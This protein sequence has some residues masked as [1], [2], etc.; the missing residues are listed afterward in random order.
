MLLE[1]DEK[2]IKKMEEN[3]KKI[4]GSILFFS[5]LAAILYYTWYGVVDKIK[6]VLAAQNS[7]QEFADKISGMSYIIPP[8]F[9]VLGLI[10]GL[11]IASFFISKKYQEII[12]KLLKK[13]DT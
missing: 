5:S 4:I 1:S 12:N 3:R 8:T 11:G 6:K 13:T 10:L 7:P 2:F 9:L